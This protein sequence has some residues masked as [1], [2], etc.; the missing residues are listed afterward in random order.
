MK[1]PGHEDNDR[2]LL[3]LTCECGKVIKAKFEGE[4][5][6]CKDYHAK[7]R[8]WLMCSCGGKIVKIK[9]SICD[10]KVNSWEQ[11]AERTPDW[12]L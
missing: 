3:T 10:S 12:L 8:V 4:R 1:T 11:P 5:G 9:C 7:D 2:G 6:S